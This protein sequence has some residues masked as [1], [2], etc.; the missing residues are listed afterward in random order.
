MKRFFQERSGKSPGNNRYQPELQADTPRF[1]ARNKSIPPSSDEIAQ[2]TRS[3]SANLRVG[4]R[5]DA[6]AGPVDRT[7][8]GLPKLTLGER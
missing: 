8:L 7:K 3:R 5:T 4:K 2:N 6:E 1:V